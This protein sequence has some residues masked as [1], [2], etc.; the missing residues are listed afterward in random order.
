MAQGSQCTVTRTRYGREACHSPAGGKTAD[1][2]LAARRRTSGSSTQSTTVGQY[3]PS[4]RLGSTYPAPPFVS[5]CVT[6]QHG[7]PDACTNSMCGATCSSWNDF[8]RQ[9]AAWDAGVSV[10][11][12][13]PIATATNGP[14][15][16]PP[17]GICGIVVVASG[18]RDLGSIPIEPR[19]GTRRL[20]SLERRAI[21]TLGAHGVA[22]ERRFC[23]RSSGRRSDGP[24]R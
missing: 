16:G 9:V 5:G 24:R 10:S 2:S 1:P 15:I 13:A 11:A 19:A 18:S 17:S 4:L 21:A 22:A 6:C 20:P 3:S 23:Q 7:M 14:L 12:S 8:V